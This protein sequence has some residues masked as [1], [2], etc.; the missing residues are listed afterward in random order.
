MVVSKK[1]LFFTSVVLVTCG[2]FVA[3]NIYTLIPIYHDVSLSLHSSPNQVVFGS[4]IFTL[5][6]SFGLITFGPL[7]DAIGR[8][9]IIVFGLLSSAIATI[10]V[11][12]SQDVWNLYIFRGLQGFSLA[13]F[14]PVTFTFCFDIFPEQKRTLVISLINT[15]F[16]VA[17]IL[18][19]V[20]S[21]WFTDLLHWRFVFIFFSL[22]YLAL[23]MITFF[24]LPKFN[25]KCIRNENVFRTFKRIFQ[26]K[27]LL[28]CYGIVITLLFSIVCFY[29]SL[30]RF[31]ADQPEELFFIRIV[32]LAGAVLSFFTG[33]LIENWG[34]KKT[35]FLGLYIGGISLFLVLFYTHFL[36]LVILS[37]LFV[38]AISILIPTMI[39][40]IG[41]IAGKDRAKALSLHSFILLIGATIASPIAIVLSFKM[42][43]L[44]L[45][46]AYISNMVLG[47]STFQGD[48]SKKSL[49]SPTLETK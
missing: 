17:G 40:I 22:S 38:S 4:T 23:F 25:E 9:K 8:R 42:T 21:Q 45:V 20:V 7:S 35:L 24:G 44:L 33:R 41:R 36:A 47:M 12:L 46:I 32:G 31:F 15:G 16:L 1:V 13:S 26:N 48:Q 5:F 34:E 3:S 10:L 6:Y 43:I 29:E 28:K 27:A 14:A 39:T 37:I 19:Q 2:I 18:G 11:G 49:V 30:S